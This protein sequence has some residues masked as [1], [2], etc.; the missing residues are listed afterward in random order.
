[1]SLQTISIDEI[2]EADLENLIEMSVAEGKAI[3]YKLDL[4]G[5]SDADK[6]EFLADASS[7]ANAIGGHIVIGMKEEQ[8]IPTELIGLPNI[9]TDQEIGRMENLLRDGL[10][11]RIPRVSIR[12]IPLNS[13]GNN[14]YAIVI[15]IPNSWLSPHRVIIKNSN[16]FYS[17]NSNGKY[18]LDVVE[19]RQAFLATAR[20]KQEIEDFRAR[21]LG[22]ILSNDVPVP[23]DDIPKLILHIVPVNI[24]PV[25]GIYGPTM[26]SNLNESLPYTLQPMNFTISRLNYDGVFVVNNH[27]NP[28]YASWHL[29]IFRNGAVEYVDAYALDTSR[30]SDI[31][32]SHME[33]TF[34]E[35]LEKCL[36]VQKQMDVSSPLL[37]MGSLL[38]VAGR[39]IRSEQQSYRRRQV[40]P[41][42]KDNLVLPDI[43]IESLDVEPHTVLRPMFDIIWN[44]AGWSKSQNY[45]EEGN[46]TAN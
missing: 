37:I 16:R 41:I 39:T 9:N 11:P 10:A 22:E 31:H 4:Y 30:N 29:Q 14:V 24:L 7:L 3:D 34:I 33:M 19:L 43:L 35:A 12:A 25:S 2:K 27:R 45:D 40:Y 36:A 28:P 1:L 8:G 23:L 42:D 46:W 38:G 26:L 13:K 15:R 18:E 21:R 5:N 20:V 17:R 32:A 6:K 44:A